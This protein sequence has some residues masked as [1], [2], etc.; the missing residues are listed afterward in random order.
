LETHQKLSEM[1]RHRCTRCHQ[2]LGPMGEQEWHLVTVWL[3]AMAFLRR[4]TV[5]LN[6]F[7]NL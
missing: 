5:I 1:E 7:K 3:L 6:A 2:H 4:G